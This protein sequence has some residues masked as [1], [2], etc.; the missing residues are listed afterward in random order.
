MILDALK[1]FYESTAGIK[2]VQVI[3]NEG[4]ILQSFSNNTLANKDVELVSNQASELNKSIKIIFKEILNAGNYE[5][6]VLTS[7]RIVYDLT[8]INQHNFLVVVMSN[9]LKIDDPF[10]PA[11]TKLLQFLKGG[12]NN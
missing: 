9:R 5:K 11:K 8:P 10:Y 1:E 3:T 12:L 2:L 4:E 7:S 6:T